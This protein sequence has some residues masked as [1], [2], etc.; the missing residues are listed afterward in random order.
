MMHDTLRQAQGG[1][2]A[3][4]LA[5][6]FALAPAKAE[7]VLR[8]ALPELAWHLHKNML[9]R[10][11]LAD[12]VEAL[13]RGH[14]IAYLSL[15]N[16]FRDEAARK[17][18]EAILGH[19]LGSKDRS[20]TVAVRVARQTGVSDRMVRDMLPGLA[21]VSMGSLALRAKTMLADI[22]AQ[23][24]PLGRLS[25]GSPHA[26]LADIL[27]RSCGAGRYGPT[28]LRRRVR[29]ALSRAAGSTGGVASWYAGFTFA[30]T[31]ARL[32]RAL[33]LRTQSAK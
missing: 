4:K 9:S 17:D 8:A 25:R 18:G 12:L 3:D 31:G 6:A 16:V 28:E 20:R 14:H 5:A 21:A 1:S 24:P 10:G 26:D 29:R 23:V 30:Q 33:S 13:A 22:V 7:A 11:G 27:R 19:I 15:D 2:V 32:L